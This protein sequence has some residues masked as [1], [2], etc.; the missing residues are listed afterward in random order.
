MN[1]EDKIRPW[2]NHICMLY[3]TELVRLVGFH[4]DD[5]DCYYTVMR[6]DG[7]AFHASAVGWLYSLK[8]FIPEKRYEAIDRCWN[9]NHC[10][11][12][13]EFLSTKSEGFLGGDL[14]DA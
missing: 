8:D 4:V 12:V 9:M 14:C 5:F 3:D 1:I 13:P 11:S 6:D 7:I 2:F 10:P